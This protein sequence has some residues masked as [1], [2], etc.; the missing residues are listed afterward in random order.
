M[1]LSLKD[2]QNIIKT[3]PVTELY[4][5]RNIHNKVYQFDICILIPKG[6]KYF[7]W[8]RQYKGQNLCILFELQQKKEIADITIR[9]SCFDSTLCAG[10]GTIIYGTIFSKK[11]YSFFMIE[12][13]YYFKDIDTRSFSQI[14]KLNI[15]Y[16]LLKYHIG[17]ISIP[18]NGLMFNIPIIETNYEA[19]MQKAYTCPYTPIWLQYRFYNKQGSYLNQKFHRQYNAIFQIT[20]MCLPDIYNIYCKNK[21]GALINYGY[22]HI[23]SY[24]VSVMMN[25]LF[26]EI[27]ENRNLD[28]LEES[29]DEDEFENISPS[30]HVYLERKIIMKCVYSTRFKRWTPLEVLSNVELSKIQDITNFEKK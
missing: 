25:E 27:K 26:R 12:D 4:Y 17:K 15:I 8:F 5:E 29:D 30:K 13:I 24:K 21:D 22:L 18:N 3:F 28:A 2:K 16:Q 6:I 19:I 11:N 7:V 14:K 1:Q 9:T 20:A 23:P 10:R